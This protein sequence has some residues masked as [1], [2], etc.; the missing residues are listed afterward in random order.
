M[1][2]KKDPASRAGG[3]I[4]PRV[5]SI[6]TANPPTKYTQRELVDLFRCDDPVL[7]QFFTSSH[8]DSRHLVLPAPGPDGS[9]PREDGTVLLEK[10][11]KYSLQVGSEAVLKCLGARGL[12][13]QDVD[14]M[15]VV[16]TTGMLCPSLSALLS[17][18]LG[19]RRDVQ[20]IDIVGMGCNAG[21]NGLFT[22][23]RFA[24]ANPE[25]N[26]LLLSSEICSAGYVFDMTVRT[27]VVNSLFGD[28]CSAV[29]LRADDGMGW[30]DGPRLLDFESYIVHEAARDM[31]FDFENGLWSFYLNRDIPYKIGATIEKPVDALLSR[32]GLKRRDIDHWLVH[33]GG[34]KVIDSVKYNLKLTDW[35]VRHT[36]SVLRNYGNISSSAVLFSYQELVREV[37][38]REGDLGVVIAM[39]PGVSLETGLLQW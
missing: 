30:R 25:T 28:A 13:P 16:T 31:R 19:M 26:V 20:R 23:A 34:K 27:A 11:R 29:L 9:I 22:A 21:V 36:R 1:G 5:V 18:H 39:G 10:H 37:V 17:A 6:G 35:D 12:T 3:S 2:A 38:T 8:I 7:T 4:F 15:V 32:H 33:S 14:S 24:R